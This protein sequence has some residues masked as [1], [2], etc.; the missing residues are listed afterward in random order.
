MSPAKTFNLPG[1]N[2]GFAIIPNDKFRFAF[3]KAAA[4]M[5]PHVN[6]LGYT[7][8]QAAFTHGSGWLAEILEYLRE[9]HRLLL[10]Q[11]N[12]I[13]NVSMLPAEATY[14]A[15]IDISR[16]NIKEPVKTLEQAGV[17]VLD[18]ADFGNPG[19]IRLNFACSRDLLKEAIKR[20]QRALQ[21]Q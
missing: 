7:A 2:C 14:L 18:G 6:A 11:M 5:L 20:I 17:G 16:L 1:L 4:G 9:N 15:W 8:C 21:R 12:T 3:K 19:F 13:P 10:D